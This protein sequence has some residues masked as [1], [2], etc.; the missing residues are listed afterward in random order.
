MLSTFTCGMFV[1]WRRFGARCSVLTGKFE[2]DLVARFPSSCVASGTREDVALVCTLGSIASVCTLESACLDC[3]F[4]TFG[5]GV[6]MCEFSMRCCWS[7]ISCSCFAVTVGLRLRTLARSAMVFMILLACVSDG[8]V[9]FL[10]FKCTVS[11]NLSL[12]VDLM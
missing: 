11:D 10:C 9:M 1:C 2:V 8:L 7:R 3:C 5:S 12:W 6:G 4:V